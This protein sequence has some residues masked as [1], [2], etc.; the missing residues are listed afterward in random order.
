MA[1]QHK[2]SVEAADPGVAVGAIGIAAPFQDVASD[3]DG[4]RHDTVTGAFKVA[5]NVDQ[6][7]ARLRSGERFPGVKPCEA[8]ARLLDEVIDGLAWHA[9]FCARSLR[10]GAPAVVALPDEPRYR[11]VGGVGL[12][13]LPRALR[14]AIGAMR[15]RYT[16][17]TDQAGRW[18]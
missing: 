11:V 13:R 10:D 3:E 4:T 15:S 12:G 5:A 9:A 7:S 6:Q 18:R 16:G 2:S 1:H 17:R 8:A 14:N